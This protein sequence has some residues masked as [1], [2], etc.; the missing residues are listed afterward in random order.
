MSNPILGV[1]LLTSNPVGWAVLGVAGYLTYK[2]GKKAGKR[3]IEQ[4][5]Q[6]CLADRAVKGVMKSAYKAKMKTDSMFSS[7]KDKYSEM[8][9]E[10][11]TEAT[12]Q[13]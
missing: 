9:K 6:E 11:Q 5:D 1:P 2:A 4:V 10:A 12:Q 7:T 8:W 3:S 13:A